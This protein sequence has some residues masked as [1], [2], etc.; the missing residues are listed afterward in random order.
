MNEGLK[1]PF[2]GEANRPDEEKGE[3]PWWRSLHERQ[4]SAEEED[5]DLSWDLQNLP[6]DLGGGA[7][8]A[9]G[10]FRSG[11]VSRERIFP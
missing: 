4:L 6:T 7:R 8:T 11:R 1:I 10:E 2:K 9:N 3:L 5:K